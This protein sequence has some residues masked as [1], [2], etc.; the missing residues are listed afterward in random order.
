MKGYL[1]DEEKTSEVIVED[2]HKR[3]YKSGDKGHLDEDNFLTIVDRYSRFAKLGGEMVSL[4]AV[5]ETIRDALG[6]PEL[7]LVAVNLPDDKKGEKIILL[8]ATETPP[9]EIKKAL[10]ESGM[11]PLMIPAK[12]SQVN[13]VPKL[14]SGKTDFATSRKVALDQV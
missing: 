3:W 4:S 7:D 6:E 2:D 11:N 1:D 9:L 12:I 10:I 5:E 14:G 8:I 13:A